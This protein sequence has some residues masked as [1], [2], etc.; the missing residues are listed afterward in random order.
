[1]VLRVVLRAQARRTGVC[2]ACG[3][4]SGMGGIYGGAALRQQ[5]HHMPVAG[6]GGLAVFRRT[7]QKKRTPDAGL[8]PPRPGPV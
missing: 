3:K 4:A 2:P 5:G 8:L 1:M 6:C 7:D